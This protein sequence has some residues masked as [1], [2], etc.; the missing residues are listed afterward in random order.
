MGPAGRNS[1]D[2]DPEPYHVT[3]PESVFQHTLHGELDSEGNF[4]GWHL[5]PGEDPDSNPPNRFINGPLVTNAYGTV[6]VHG[7]LGY[8]DDEWNLTP[9]DTRIHKHTFFPIDWTEADI[10][11]AGQQIFDNGTERHGGT[12]VIGNYRGVDMVGYLKD[13]VP[14]SFFPTG[15]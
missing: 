10:R 8:V 1:V 13:G 4:G 6:S 2:G 9:K 12:M 15:G 3:I 11:E 7:T 14:T 5:H